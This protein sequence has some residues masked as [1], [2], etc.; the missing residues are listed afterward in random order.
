M[1]I[2][3]H[4]GEATGAENV[5]ETICHGAIKIKEFELLPTLSGIG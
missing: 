2:K 5:R 4:E 3:I 1:L